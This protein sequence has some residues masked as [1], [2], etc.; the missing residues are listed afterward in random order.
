[1]SPN[2]VK[3]WTKLRS[4]RS[5]LSSLDH[6]YGKLRNKSGD[7]DVRKRIHVSRVYN[8]SIQPKHIYTSFSP[9]MVLP[10]L[11]RQALVH[12]D[13]ARDGCSILGEVL[14][15]LSEGMQWVGRVCDELGTL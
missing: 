12:H 10:N 15:K 9:H 13:A 4:L 2:E 14:G 6:I 11:F 8:S 3:E 1:M 5:S 7:T